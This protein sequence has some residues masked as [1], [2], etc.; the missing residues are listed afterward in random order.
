MIPEMKM[1]TDLKSV[2]GRALELRGQSK[3]SPNMF[4]VGK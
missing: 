4:A 2:P 3:K 1:G